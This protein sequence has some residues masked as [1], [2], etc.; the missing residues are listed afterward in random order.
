MLYDIDKGCI[1]L[2]ENICK[3][4]KILKWSK[5]KVLLNSEQ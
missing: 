5:K 2:N 1:G 4:I 3:K